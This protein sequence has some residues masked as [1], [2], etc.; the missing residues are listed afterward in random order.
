MHRILMGE[1]CIDEALVT[2]AVLAD[3]MNENRLRTW[4]TE[5]MPRL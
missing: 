4:R 3:T 5:G 2:T 1:K